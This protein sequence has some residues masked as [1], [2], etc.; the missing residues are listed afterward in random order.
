MVRKLNYCILSLCMML[1]ASCSTDVDDETLNVYH[2]LELLNK[3]MDARLKLI[4]KGLGTYEGK[5]SLNVYNEKVYE[6]NLSVKEDSFLFVLPEK[7]FVDIILELNNNYPD[8]PFFNSTQENWVYMETPQRDGYKLE[9]ISD[10]TAYMC[11]SFGNIYNIM[12][13]LP[14]A[15]YPPLGS[16]YFYVTVEGVPYRIDP[17]FR[18]TAMYDIRLMKW[19]LQYSLSSITVINLE[20][21]WYQSWGF[22]PD[23]NL[24]KYVT[25]KKIG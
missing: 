12:P 9:G 5:W 19:T 21:G 15:D 8:E 25:T 17:Y 6:G 10:E 14:N 16:P 1:T 22:E 18:G 24:I 20:T 13:N 4:E 11:S 3:E 2:Q 7:M 23:I